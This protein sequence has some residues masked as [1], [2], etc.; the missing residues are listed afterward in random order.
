M[1]IIVVL[2]GVG[3]TLVVL[4]I[5]KRLREFDALI[6]SLRMLL[7]AHTDS[8]GKIIRFHDHRIHL[9]AALGQLQHSIIGAQETIKAQC[10]SANCPVVPIIERHL[11]DKNTHFAHLEQ[12]WINYADEAKENRAETLE[13]LKN[14]FDRM[15]SAVVDTLGRMASVIETTMIHLK[16]GGSSHD[17]K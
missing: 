1:A 7:E 14:I 11:Q 13:A 9:Q 8:E 2:A 4:A 3:V 6:E 10:G 15:S 5:I 17:K 12:L 16:N